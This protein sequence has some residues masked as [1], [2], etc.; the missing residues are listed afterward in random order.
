M[1]YYVEE[2]LSNFNFW[3]GGETVQNSCQMSNSTPWNR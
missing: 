1:R 3:S 2:S